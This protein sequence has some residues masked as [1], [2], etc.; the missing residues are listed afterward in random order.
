MLTNNAVKGFRKCTR[1]LN[2]QIS[3][4]PAALL[5]NLSPQFIGSTFVSENLFS[6]ANTSTLSNGLVNLKD[7]NISGLFN[8]IKH[9]SQVTLPGD[10][11]L[12]CVR[13]WSFTHG[14]NFHRVTSHAFHYPSYQ[15]LR[16]QLI[17]STTQKE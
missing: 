14:R 16:R 11:H 3:F 8:S 12:A 2:R 7:M 5:S 6:A 17:S 15:H 10:S 1:S 4:T 13:L 9:L